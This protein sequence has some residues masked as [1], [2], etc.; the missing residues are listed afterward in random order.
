[1]T[2]IIKYHKA[3]SEIACFQSGDEFW[4]GAYSDNLRHENGEPKYYN[5]GFSFAS[6]DRFAGV[7]EGPE[8]EAMEKLESMTGNES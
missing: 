4:I 5:L 7:P 1:M 3:T 2:K 6:G 8:V